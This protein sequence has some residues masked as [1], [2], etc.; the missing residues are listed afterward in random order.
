VTPLKL[1][2]PSPSG[3]RQADP[4][5][6]GYYDPRQGHYD[7]KARLVRTNLGNFDRHFRD[8]ENYR[9]FNPPR[10][11]TYKGFRPTG[12]TYNA[13][14]A[15]HEL[16]VASIQELIGLAN[17]SDQGSLLSKYQKVIDAQVAIL[18][19][20]YEYI[21][22]LRQQVLDTI[23]A[24]GSPPLPRATPPRIPPS[25]DRLRPSTSAPE[26]NPTLATA[27]GA[28]RQRDSTNSQS[29]PITLT[30]A[31]RMAHS[32]VNPQQDES[33]STTSYRTPPAEGSN[34]SKVATT[35]ERSGSK[36]R[37]SS[38]NSVSTTSSRTKARIAQREA[39]L[40]LRELEQAHRLEEE[41]E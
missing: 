2:I 28:D 36:T 34:P 39:A 21:Q 35:Q 14:L 12:L 31:M 22:P 11:D 15:S 38:N 37:R 24:S 17:P 7:I 3:R 16:C 9:L 4:G 23:N 32:D 26:I 41:E 1:A 6:L 8:L 5:R 30:D 29:T 19:N 33:T 20:A 13:L 25:S 27:S 10:F 18:K 40:S